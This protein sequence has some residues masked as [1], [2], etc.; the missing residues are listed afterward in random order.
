MLCR[1]LVS[2]QYYGI[3]CAGG[4]GRAGVGGMGVEYHSRRP[5]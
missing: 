1:R 5:K 4:G 2:G 3:V